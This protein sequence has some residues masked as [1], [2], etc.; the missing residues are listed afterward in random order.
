MPCHVVCVCVP[1]CAL[2]CCQ[3]AGELCRVWLVAAAHASCSHTPPSRA[4]KCVR[5]LLQ[6][7]LMRPHSLGACSSRTLC[8]PHT[9]LPRVHLSSA[10]D[11]SLAAAAIGASHACCRLSVCRRMT[12]RC[13]LRFWPSSLRSGASLIVVVHL[14]CLPRHH[15]KCVRLGLGV[16]VPR[17]WRVAARRRSGAA[18]PPVCSRTQS[19]GH[20]VVCWDCW[21]CGRV[22]A[23]TCRH[24]CQRRGVAAW[25]LGA[26]PV[27]RKA[28]NK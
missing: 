7:R 14:R 11:I 13:R 22:R 6:P 4:S 15:T 9:R 17:A 16:C 2:V 1:V 10:V 28:I 20:G 24:C 21:P 26:Q 12:M 23:C 19:V 18:L 25:R 5:C 3:R 27:R 8:L